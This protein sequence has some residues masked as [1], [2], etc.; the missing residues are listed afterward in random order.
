[1][2]KTSFAFYNGR[3]TDRNNIELYFSGGGGGG[4]NQSDKPWRI[5]FGEKF[6]LRKKQI[7]YSESYGTKSARQTFV[8]FHRGILWDI[9]FRMIPNTVAWFTYHILAYWELE[10]DV[11][12]RRVPFSWE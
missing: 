11:L 12:L 1:M 5:V 4:V 10:T 3:K 7:L 2:M 6:L 9:A 8:T